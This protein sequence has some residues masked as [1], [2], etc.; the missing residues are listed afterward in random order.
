[1]ES[2][3]LC[4]EFFRENHKLI[5]SRAGF[6]DIREYCYW[7]AANCCIN[8]KDMLA[9]LE[10]APEKWAF[11][12][13]SHAILSSCCFCRFK[14]LCNKSATVYSAGFKTEEGWR[15]ANFM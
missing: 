4:V 8:M 6:T 3:I 15:E 12:F 13:L 5:F 11:F 2:D 9:D 7:D 10:V 1:M 14:I